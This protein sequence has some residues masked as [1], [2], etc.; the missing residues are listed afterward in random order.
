MGRTNRM[1]RD[2]VQAMEEHWTDYRR[3]LRCNDQAAFDRLFEHAR[4]HAD[5]G[6]MQNHPSTEV[7]VLLSIVLEHQ[8]HI[9]DLDDRLDH[10]ETDLNPED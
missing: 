8:L 1:Y 9:D 7:T 3:V 4:T 2:L 6:S 5:A 10:L